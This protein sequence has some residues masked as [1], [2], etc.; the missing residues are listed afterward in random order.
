METG[1]T[2]WLVGI[3]FIFSRS[4]S[5]RVQHLVSRYPGTETTSVRIF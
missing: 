4:F 3:V 2:Q 1:I 5:K